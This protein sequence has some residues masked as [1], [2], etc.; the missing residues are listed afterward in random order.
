MGALATFP[1]SGQETALA[2]REVTEGR[3][4]DAV[5]V[6]A[7]APG[8]VAQ[9]GSLSRPGARILLFAQTSAGESIELDG[10]EI[11]AGERILLG[12][13]SADV[14][15]QDESARLVLDGSLPVE[16]LISHRLPLE[17]IEQGIEMAT[18][19]DSRTLKIIVHPQR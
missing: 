4:A 17:R 8:L 12:C 3:G 15:L 6:A 13:Y 2:L 16:N 9:A 18:H 14:D 11:C 5:I 1:S 7:A 10:S 19:P